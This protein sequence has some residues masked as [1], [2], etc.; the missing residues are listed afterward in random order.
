[1][2]RE[3]SNGIRFV[4]EDLLPPILRDTNLFRLTARAVWGKHVDDLARFRQRA[5]FLS[6][7][8]YEQLYLHH[9]RVH[10]DTD[11]SAA[12]VK[13]IITETVGPDICDVGCG[14]GFLLRAIRNATGQ[15]IGRQVGVDFVEPE[16]LETSGI[17]FVKAP[18]ERLPFPDQSFDTVICTHVLEHILEYR[19]A[20]KELRRICRTKLIIVV[21]KEREGIY[22]FNPHF[23]F[24]PYR[25]SLL[26]AMTPI[27]E[28]FSCEVIGRDIFY[29]ET[30]PQ[31][32]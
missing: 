3:T 25:H 22:T 32:Q 15:P 7:S 11:N 17:E 26:R 24:F 5:P 29:C 31:V 27:P 1:M 8:E 14:T 20:I 12:C 23:N 16:G 9:P 2:N 30:I 18:I 10:H 28:R 6:K 21:P 13:R 19:E 4:I